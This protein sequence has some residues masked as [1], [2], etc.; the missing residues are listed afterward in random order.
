MNKGIKPIQN[1]EDTFKYEDKVRYK[2]IIS[3]FNTLNNSI[4]I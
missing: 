1:R 3:K 4:N 2:E